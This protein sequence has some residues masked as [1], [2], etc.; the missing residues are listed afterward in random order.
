MAALAVLGGCTR[1]PAG[2]VRSFA[3][4]VRGAILVD[5]SA[6]GYA[7]PAALQMLDAVVADGA[8]GVTILVTAYQATARASRLRAADPRTPGAAAVRT[9]AEAAVSRGLAVSIKPHVDVD[10][11]AWRATIDPPDPAAWFESYRAFVLPWARL[12]DSLGAARFVAGTELAGTIDHEAEWRTTIAALR[13][14]FGGTLVYAASWDEAQLV[15]FWD[16]LDLAGVDFYYP[17]AA[18]ERAGRFELLSGWAPWLSRLE[19]L[20]ERTGKRILLTEIGYRSIDGA[21]LAPHALG[22]SDA[23]D[24]G[25]QADLYWAAL[26]SVGDLP[27]MEGLEW[28]NYRAD[29][30]GGSA[31]GDFTPFGKPAEL[32][33]RAAWAP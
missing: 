31:D 14:A 9:I 12:A 20:H 10:D 5:W 17:V 18:R 26:Q 30:A 25:E 29:G 32:E 19:R 4:P 11:G 8:N 33:L 23:I 13:T 21:G 1:L 7:Q 16:A 28:W 15:R 24:L 3:P 27:W 22:P 2:P 6:D